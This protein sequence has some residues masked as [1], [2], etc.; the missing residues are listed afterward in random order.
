MIHHCHIVVCRTESSN[1]CAHLC[2][3]ILNHV[4][5]DLERF[6]STLKAKAAA[7]AELEKKSKKS[8]RK[9]NDG[10]TSES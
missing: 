9:K 1:N 4:L 6:M 8:R 5:D 2:Q 7:W 3:D 10:M